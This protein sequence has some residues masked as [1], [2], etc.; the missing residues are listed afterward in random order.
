M[1]RRRPADKKRRKRPQQR[2]NAASDTAR[3]EHTPLPSSGGVPPAFPAASGLHRWQ[4]RQSWCCRVREHEPGL[5]SLFGAFL[6]RLRH[7][8][9]LFCGVLGGK[10]QSSDIADCG[11][12]KLVR[13]SRSLCNG[14]K[15]LE[16]RKRSPLER[17]RCS[18]G[19]P[20]SAIL[21]PPLNLSYGRCGL[22]S[23]GLWGT[24][25]SWTKDLLQMR[26]RN[27]TDGRAGPP[28]VSP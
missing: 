17:I 6:T 1:A 28:G 13:I 18:S 24:S 2:T 3:F 7:Y 19:S 9:L 12:L 20:S 16:P 14:N 11:G 25:T 23:P 15:G 8:W 26:S 10:H 4:D 22:A 21:Q 5:V 27:I